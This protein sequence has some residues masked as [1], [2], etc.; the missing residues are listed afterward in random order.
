M[1]IEKGTK[2]MVFQAKKDENR[3]RTVIADISTY[4]GRDQDD[5]PRYASWRARFVGE[6]YEDALGLEDK[7]RIIIQPGIVDNVYNKEKEKLYVTV[8]IFRFENDEE[9]TS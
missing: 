6:A 1:N 8:T 5:K 4:E 7:D 3:K 9:A 2:A